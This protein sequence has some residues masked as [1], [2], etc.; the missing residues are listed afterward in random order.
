VKQHIDTGLSNLATEMKALIRLTST[1]PTFP[2]SPLLPAQSTVHSS[3]LVPPH[4]SSFPLP[5]SPM[6]S[7]SIGSPSTF[8]SPSIASS[9][10]LHVPNALIS[11]NEEV[12]TLRQEVIDLQS[13]IDELRSQS[14]SA[15]VLAKVNAS[16]GLLDNGR[17]QLEKETSKLIMKGDE[18]QDAID[19]LK[20]DVASGKTTLSSLQHIFIT[21]SLKEVNDER[22]KI[23]RW[24][25]EVQPSWKT[26]WSGEL[27]IIVQEQ[28]SLKSHE[29]MLNDLQLDLVEASRVFEVIQQVS[30]EQGG[31]NGGRASRPL[32][33]VVV[34]RSDSLNGTAGEGDFFQEVQGLNPEHR[35]L[36]AIAESERRREVKNANRSDELTDE[37]EAFVSAGRLKQSGGIE[38]AERLRQI[39]SEATLKAMFAS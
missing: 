33:E 11:D 13:V 22:D 5:A 12:K 34:S 25:N 3:N 29:A 16:R 39:R 2:R 27:A 23:V 6:P 19:L 18:V 37:L 32:R 4:P 36:Q 28:Q 1:P 30:K 15:V 9:S 17:A 24:I 35:R 31:L 7:P 8:L 14:K 20:R 38:E 26:M 21:K 10:T